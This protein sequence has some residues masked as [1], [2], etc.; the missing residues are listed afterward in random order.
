MCAY[1]QTYIYTVNVDK[2]EVTLTMGVN[3]N[4]AGGALRK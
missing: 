3:Y 4:R 1:T 2:M